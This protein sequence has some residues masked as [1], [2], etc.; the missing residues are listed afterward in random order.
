MELIKFE[1]YIE[2]Y[3]HPLVV[4]I[5]SFDG[6]HLGHQ[7][8]IKRTISES[9]MLNF[10]SAVITFEPHPLITIN[11]KNRSN[12]TSITEKV[13]LISDFGVD[14]LI[15]INFNKEFSMISKF[16][17]VNDYLLSIN[18]KEVIVGN[19]FKF[20]YKGEGAAKEISE[21]S[22][23]QIKTLILD[24]IKFNDEKIGSSKI[25]KLLNEGQIELVND[26]LGYNYFFNGKVIKGKQIGRK[27][28]FPT[29][30]IDNDYVKKLLKVGVYGVRV[31]FNSNYY[32]GMMNI[33]HNP[34]CNYQDDLSI[35]VNL[36]EQNIDLY[37]SVL[38]IECFCYVRDEI[39]FKNIDE[40][41][42]RLR[43]DKEIIINKN[44]M[45]A[46]K[47]KK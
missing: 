23:Y 4:T 6:I 15:V 32:L 27:L 43:L 17:F 12:I 14:Y 10:K 42:A 47:W 19:D 8:L 22:D 28:G 34:T 16:D 46:K 38:K 33:G 21:L 3:N 20:G 44:L 18:V 29:A 35:E 24:L 7:E 1:E 25:I 39:R 9:K 26:L 11:N 37:D 45:L 40:L 30:N 5:G 2:R 13:S 36:F 31:Y 41:I